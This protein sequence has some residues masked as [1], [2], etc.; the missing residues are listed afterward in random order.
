MM[1]HKGS[2]Y[3]SS[4]KIFELILSMFFGL[5]MI[6]FAVDGK[7][8]KTSFIKELFA[9]VGRVSFS[10]YLYNYIFYA[11]KPVQ[12]NLIA[13]LVLL[14]TVTAFGI[15]IYQIVEVQTENVRKRVFLRKAQNS[16]AGQAA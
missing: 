15:L 5:S 10:I 9:L 14:I 3:S 16:Q 6:Y 1:F 11:V 13:G 4:K 2:S 7:Q 8:V 12:Y